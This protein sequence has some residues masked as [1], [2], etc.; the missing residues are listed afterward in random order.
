MH[1]AL[2]NFTLILFRSFSFG[3]RVPVRYVREFSLF[4]V[5]SLSK[6]CPSAVRTS[7]ANVVLEILRKSELLLLIIF[8][9]YQ[10]TNCI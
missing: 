5:C 7:A 2:L 10:N 3:L 8:S 6:N 1:S 4:D 9:H